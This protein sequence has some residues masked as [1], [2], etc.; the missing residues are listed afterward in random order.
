MTPSDE[1]ELYQML[2]T[3]LF[4]Q[5]LAPYATRVVRVRV[6]PLFTDDPLSAG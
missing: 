3:A 5:V 4:T 1:N 2:Y 6:I